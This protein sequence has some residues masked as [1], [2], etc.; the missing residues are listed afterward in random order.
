MA[1]GAEREED[2]KSGS[3]PETGGAERFGWAVANLGSNL[4]R[5]LDGL[6]QAF[7]RLHPPDLPRI[8]DLLT[9]VRD[10]LREA[11]RGF[12]E[13]ETP[14]RLREFRDRFLEAARLADEA[15][16]GLV[17]PAA[18]E[19]SVG[20]ALQ[21]MH[22]HARAQAELYP[23]RRTLP[24]VSS[25]F[26]EPFR[27]EHLDLLEAPAGGRARVGLF[28][29]GE[30]DGRGGFDLYVPESHDGSQAWP[31]VVALHGGSGN[32][33]DFLWTW[34]REARSRRFLLLAP[35]SQG[36]TWSLDDPGVDGSVLVRTTE[37]V[38]SEWNV[39]ARHV[40]LTGL[41]DGATMTLL[42]GLAPDAPYTH[43]APVS[44]VLHPANFGLG[45]LDRARG[46]PIRLVHGAL[47]WLFPVALAREAARALEGAGA[48]LVYREIEDLSHTYPREE[49]ARIIE[50]F[51]PRR[52]VSSLQAGEKVAGEKMADEGISGPGTADPT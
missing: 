25:F 44:G 2:G 8:R 50:W 28:R 9:P 13:C 14:D 51:D 37:W 1:E 41:S 52:A 10:A 3:G 11:R 16:S 45:N 21:A 12:D 31:L 40:L 42:A 24:P 23:L 38:S 20:R 18:P 19:E 27:R 33:S 4:L 15:L 43:L 32:G 6:E 39:D 22:L 7:R 49:N 5:A 17:D 46:R 35:T 30:V 48:E 26:A 34:L 36:A 29:S 47:D